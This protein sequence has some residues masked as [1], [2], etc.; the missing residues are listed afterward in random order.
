MAEFI[1]RAL[2]VVLGIGYMLFLPRA[3]FWPRQRP[4]YVLWALL[5]NEGLVLSICLGTIYA[6]RN[7]LPLL[8]FG[9]PMRAFFLGIGWMYLFSAWRDYREEQ[10]KLDQGT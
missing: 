7:G 8:W 6:H 2:T 4:P 10:R 1:L 9:A 3:M 5:V